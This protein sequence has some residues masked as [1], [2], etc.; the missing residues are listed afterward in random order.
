MSKEHYQSPDRRYVS[1][2]EWCRQ[3]AALADA[4]CRCDNPILDLVDDAVVYQLLTAIH[5][6]GNALVKTPVV[7]ST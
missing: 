3:M 7:A 1:D 6:G 5:H 4:M 2:E